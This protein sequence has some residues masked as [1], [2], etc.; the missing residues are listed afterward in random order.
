MKKIILLVVVIC[1]SVAVVV[2]A[3]SHPDD[4]SCMALHNAEHVQAPRPGDEDL[5]IGDFRERG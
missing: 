2:S 1:L 4:R 5:G 3:S